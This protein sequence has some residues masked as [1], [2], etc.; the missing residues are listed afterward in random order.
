MTLRMDPPEVSDQAFQPRV[1]VFVNGHPLGEF[2][3]TRNPERMGSYRIR[4]PAAIVRRLNRLDLMASHTVPAGLAG[5][6][7]ASLPADSPVAF[8]LWYVRLETATDQE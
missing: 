2:N 5:P 3:F 7:F 4:V 6:A 8:R 1:T